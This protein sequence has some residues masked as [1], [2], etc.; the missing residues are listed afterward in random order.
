[1]ICLESLRLLV[2]P[3][4]ALK[5]EEQASMPSRCTD[6]EEEDRYTASLFRSAAE[7]IYMFYR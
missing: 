4:V 7:T 3:V 2:K 1:M 6:L 5:M